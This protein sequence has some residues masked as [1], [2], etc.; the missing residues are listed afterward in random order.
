MKD[1]KIN[2]RLKVTATAKRDCSVTEREFLQTSVYTRKPIKKG[3]VIQL[4]VYKVIEFTTKSLIDVLGK[5]DVT[6]VN[7]ENYLTT[8]EKDFDFI[9]E[10][11][12]PSKVIPV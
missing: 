10:K 11:V 4:P 1:I 7:G 8:F 9:V 5:M 2:R 6:F 12:K 3:E